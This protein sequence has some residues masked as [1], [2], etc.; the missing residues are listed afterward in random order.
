MSTKTEIE[1]TAYLS[2]SNASALLKAVE[3][4][5]EKKRFALTLDLPGIT[6]ELWYLHHLNKDDIRG[7]K[8]PPSLSWIKTKARLL[9]AVENVPEIKRLWSL[10]N[11]LNRQQGG[12]YGM[13]KK[14][15]ALAKETEGRVLPIT[16]STIHKAKGLEWD[17]VVLHADVFESLPSF[18]TPV[19]REE[20][21]AAL[22]L[23]YVAV[24]RAKVRTLMPEELETFIENLI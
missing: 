5:A 15:E 24:T 7:K 11:L 9:E 12:L 8:V 1:T 18:E 6:N 20:Q 3:L 23:L 14:F 22:R 10:F 19:N 13:L 16:L 21:L 2:R 17:E 4:F